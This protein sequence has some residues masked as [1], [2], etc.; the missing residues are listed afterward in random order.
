MLLVIPDA[1]VLNTKLKSLQK[2]HAA[3]NLYMQ[4]VL[5]LAYKINLTKEGG[6]QS[7]F[8]CSK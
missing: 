7:W 8:L 4:S 1:A 2:E 6:V 3:I 5:Y